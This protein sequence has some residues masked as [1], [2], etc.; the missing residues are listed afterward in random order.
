MTDS[1]AA[2]TLS[3]A[4]SPVRSFLVRLWTEVREAAGAEACLRLYVRDL[5]SGEERYLSD[6]DRVADFLRHQAGA[7]G[8]AAGGGEGAKA[9]PTELASR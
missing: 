2:S 9:S 4:S 1:K 6:P 8:A 3:S 5:R 7:G